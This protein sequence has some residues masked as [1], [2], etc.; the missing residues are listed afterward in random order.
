MSKLF[1]TSLALLLILGCAQTPEQLAEIKQCEA[2]GNKAY[3]YSL[4][5]SLYSCVTPAEQKRLDRLELACVS[6]GGTVDYHVSGKYEN[7]KRAAAVKINVTNNN[8][9]GSLACVPDLNG[10]GRCMGGKCC[11]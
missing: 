7:C 11:S 2:A 8:S 3:V 5:K 9:S 1:G 6:A 4:S 10:D